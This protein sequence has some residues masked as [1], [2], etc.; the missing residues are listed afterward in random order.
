[1]LKKTS[2][3]QF[4]SL[5]ATAARVVLYQEIHGDLI[6]P[7]QVYHQL[8]NDCTKNVLIEFTP[9]HGAQYAVV[10]LNPLA[11]LTA[12]GEDVTVTVDDNTTHYRHD[13][14][15]CLRELRQ[16]LACADDHPLSKLTAGAIGYLSYDAVRYIE[17]LPDQ[18]RKDNAIAD[19]DITFYRNTVTFDLNH[20]KVLVCHVVDV[21]DDLASV[22][23]NGMMIIAKIIEKIFTTKT[24]TQK[25]IHANKTTEFSVDLNDDDYAEIVNKAKHYIKMGDI[26]QVVPSRTFQKNYHGETFDVYRALKQVS[27]SPYHFYLQNRHM[28]IVGASP[29]KIVSV[30]NNVIDSVPLAGTRSRGNGKTDAQLAAELTADPKEI[31]EHVMLVDLARNDVGAVSI[32]GSVKVSAYLQPINFS[33][34]MHIAST[35]QGELAKNYDVIDVLKATFPAGTLSGA[36]KIRAMEIIDEIENSR[37]GIYG[38]AIIALDRADNLDTCITI[39]TALIKNKI[40][41]V[42]A[43][44]GIV[45]DSDPYAEA[46]ESRQK[47]TSVMSAIQLAEGGLL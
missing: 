6:T 14:F 27:P 44:G 17:K 2:Y 36:P 18:H 10:G 11:S 25:Q 42:R 32:P 8:A 4:I 41:Y 46:N 16:Q 39:R 13:P 35:V 20:H 34:V 26:F 23:E 47:A 38:G 30:K 7:T 9:Q 15:Q 19:I 3:N 31:A 28:A 24:Q 29:E 1:V 5:S 45:H 21:T 40:A 12:N 33:H 37:R 22:Y 43:G